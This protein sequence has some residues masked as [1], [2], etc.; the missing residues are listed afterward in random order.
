MMERIQGNDDAMGGT[1]DSKLDRVRPEVNAEDC[2]ERKADQEAKHSM[3]GVRPFKFEAYRSG[4][5]QKRE[6][7]LGRENL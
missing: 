6:A 2:G 5:F 7:V 3:V 4:F 1:A